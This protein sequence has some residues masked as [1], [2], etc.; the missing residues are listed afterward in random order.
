MMTNQAANIQL[1]ITGTYEIRNKDNLLLFEGAIQEFKMAPMSKFQYPLSWQYQKLEAGT[2]T[3][4]LQVTANGEKQS[5][6]NS[7]TVNGLGIAKA[8]QAQAKINPEIQASFPSW[9]PVA[10]ELFLLLLVLLFIGFLRVKRRPSRS[11]RRI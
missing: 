5:F 2:Y 11:N 10:I 6:E 8:Q 7:F 1:N 4:S 3:L 9:F